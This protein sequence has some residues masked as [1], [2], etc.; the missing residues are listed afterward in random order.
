MGFLIFGLICTGISLFFFGWYSILMMNRI[1]VDALVVNP[2]EDTCQSTSDDQ[3]TDYPCYAAVVQFSVNGSNY[4]VKTGFRAWTP[5]RIGEK[6]T[7]FYQPGHPEAAIL[8]YDGVFYFGILPAAFGAGG[9]VVWILWI[10][11][12]NQSRR[13]RKS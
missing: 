11:T 4:Q 6:V 3:T 12:I 1:P 10:L 5:Y 2:L 7:L 9:I 8:S 13:S